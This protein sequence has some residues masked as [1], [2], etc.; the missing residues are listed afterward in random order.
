MRPCWTVAGQPKKG[1]VWEQVI[2]LFQCRSR[3]NF[4]EL[5]YLGMPQPARRDFQLR[6]KASSWSFHGDGR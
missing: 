6:P 3:Q 1:Q 5:S 4:K 2:D